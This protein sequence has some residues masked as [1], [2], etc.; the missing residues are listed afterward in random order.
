MKRLNFR[1]NFIGGLIAIIPLAFLFWV[2]SLVY[3]PVANIIGVRGLTTTIIIF[4]VFVVIVYLVGFALSHIKIFRK[5]KE[6]IEQKIF[7]KIPLVKPVYKFSKDLVENSLANKVYDETV[8][9]YPFGREC[10]GLIAFLTNKET[11]TVFAPSSPNPLSGHVY[12]Y[13]DYDL[14]DY[15]YDQAVKTLM[16]VG[17]SVDKVEV[18]NGK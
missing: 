12:M 2:L 13:C 18:T 14:I 4:V 9:A 15:T 11:S 3:N 10:A 7:Y 17:L 1:N 5:L 6:L 16:S 8:I